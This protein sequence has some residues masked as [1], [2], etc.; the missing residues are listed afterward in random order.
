MPR[1]LHA[2]LV[3]TL[4]GATA[5]GLAACGGEDAKL[6]PGE[7]AREITANL[8]TVKQL[9]GEEDCIG[10]ESAVQ[11]VGEQIE[12]LEGVDPKL[13]RAL[14]EG[15]ERL[16]EVIVDCEESSSAAIAPAEAPSEFEEEGEEETEKPPKQKEPKEKEAK[17][18]EE[19]Q[20][21]ESPPQPKGKAK[22]LENGH[23]PPPAEEPPAE[24]APAESPSG[25][26][27]PGAPATG[28]K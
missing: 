26:V 4:T 15:A 13:K 27:G 28:G 18:G 20:A 19:E 2:V 12:A 6:L 10:A 1:T 25:G 7:T 3:L 22:G 24:E 17:P 8:D 5:L 9:A 16:E 23:E 11:Q 21:Q 14:E